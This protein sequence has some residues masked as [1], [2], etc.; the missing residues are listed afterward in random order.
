M[1]R[2]SVR[3]ARSTATFRALNYALH[4]RRLTSVVHACSSSRVRA[5]CAPHIDTD[6]VPISNIAVRGRCDIRGHGRCVTG[7][8]VVLFRCGCRMHR[9]LHASVGIF[10]PNRL[11]VIQPVAQRR[12][13]P[14]NTWMT[15]VLR[16]I[17]LMCGDSWRDVLASGFSVWRRTAHTYCV[18]RL[19]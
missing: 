15:E 4:V 5:D 16:H 14:R 3:A 10:V 19:G 2:I 17:M 12:G 9:D 6:A 8:Q 13:R 1:V 11:Q 7:A 18:A